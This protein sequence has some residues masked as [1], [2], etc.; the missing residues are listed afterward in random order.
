[1][2]E[3]I[4]IIFVNAAIIIVLV[5]SAVLYYRWAQKRERRGEK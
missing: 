2:G 5:C 4:K 1:M 3:V